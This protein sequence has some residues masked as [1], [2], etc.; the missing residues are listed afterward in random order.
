MYRRIVVFAVLLSL[1]IAVVAVFLVSRLS[2]VQIGMAEEEV[3][4]VLGGKGLTLQFQNDEE[5][6]YFARL[7][8]MPSE[9]GAVMKRW[10][11][12]D[13]STHILFD[14]DSRV[15]GVYSSQGIQRYT[16]VVLSAFGLRN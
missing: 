4:S 11:R 12:N 16:N 6:K 8:S 1:S 2:G 5:M 14:A 9:K 3:E 10:D 7:L 15:V 13:L